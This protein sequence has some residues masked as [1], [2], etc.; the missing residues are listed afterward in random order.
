MVQDGSGS[1]HRPVLGGMDGFNH[2]QSDSPVQPGYLAIS[3]SQL[4]GLLGLGW[5]GIGLV[6]TLNPI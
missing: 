4:L 1:G 2:G 6:S 5:K 3:S